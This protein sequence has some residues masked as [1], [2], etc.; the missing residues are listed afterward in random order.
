[1][2]AV[3]LVME[4]ELLLADEPTTALDAALQVQLLNQLKNLVKMEKRGLIFISHD[5]GVLRSIADDLAILY[6]G[7]I[8]E[9]GPAK[10][11]L[12]RP[13]HHYTHAL[14]QSLP[15]LVNERI[16]PKP[17]SG[18]LPPVDLKP[19]GCVFSDR[20]P[21]AKDICTKDVPQLQMAPP[22]PLLEPTVSVL[23]GHLVACH[24]PRV[25]SHEQGD[26]ACA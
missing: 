13:Q 18:T 26:V 22:P 23:G 11:I 2:L 8:V 15:R 9:F 12:Q 16:L 20:C 3:A 10:E 4:P 24:F 19:P 25:V 21:N 17:I 14:I 6:A 1:M 5:L 7:R